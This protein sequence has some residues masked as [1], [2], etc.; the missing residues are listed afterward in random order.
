MYLGDIPAPQLWKSVIDTRE[1]LAAVR[2]A[3]GVID[4]FVVPPGLN[5]TSDGPNGGNTG[6]VL[7][8]AITANIMGLGSADIHAVK[9]ASMNAALVA[10]NNAINQL[11]S[12]TGQTTAIAPT[13]PVAATLSTT[14]PMVTTPN[15]PS[16]P[17]ITTAAPLTSPYSLPATTSTA[18]PSNMW[19][20]LLGGGAALLFLMKGKRGG[21]QKKARGHA[22]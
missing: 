2:N 10:M 6:N 17:S 4:N 1:T 21:K 16:L 7:A 14:S 18:M 9:R 3:H 13:I 19:L 20:Y 11:Q 8:A 15:A 12:P 5:R 22:S